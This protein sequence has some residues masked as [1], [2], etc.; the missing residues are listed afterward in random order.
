M[1]AFITW[2]SVL[3][4]PED[5]G[6]KI[7]TFGCNH[8][9]VSRAVSMDKAA[10]ALPILQSTQIGFFFLYILEKCA[11]PRMKTFWLSGHIR[12]GLPRSS[13]PCLSQKMVSCSAPRFGSWRHMNLHYLKPSLA[14]ISPRYGI[15]AISDKGPKTQEAR[16]PKEARCCRRPLHLPCERSKITS[17]GILPV[18]FGG[19]RN[20]TIQVFHWAASGLGKQ[21]ASLQAGVCM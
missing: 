5:S 16:M 19:L 14:Q 15:T 21:P 6:K 3:A 12:T 4:K 10:G 8:G 1:L 17:Q 7:F 11:N 18:S 20:H 13:Y 2:D 9:Q